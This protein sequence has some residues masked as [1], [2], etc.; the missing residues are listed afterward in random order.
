[1]MFGYRLET[2]Y[3]DVAPD[4]HERVSVESADRVN[5]VKML[6]DTL[7]TTLRAEPVPWKVVVIREDCEQVTRNDDGECFECAPPKGGRR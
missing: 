5:A 7:N 1:M 6:A 3:E 4:P 2:F